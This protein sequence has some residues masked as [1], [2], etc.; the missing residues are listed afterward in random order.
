MVTYRIYTINAAGLGTLRKQ[1]SDL[2]RR[3]RTVIEL[4]RSL[5]DEKT[6]L[7]DCESDDEPRLKYYVHLFATPSRDRFPIHAK[8][9]LC[10]C[11]A[12]LSVARPRGPRAK[13]DGRTD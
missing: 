5:P 10:C 8:D 9:A 11:A 1:L 13:R 4:L 3:L 7:L 2:R 12:V 6:W